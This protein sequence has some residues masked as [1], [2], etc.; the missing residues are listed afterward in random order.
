M[1]DEYIKKLVETRLRSMPPNASFSVGKFG[2]FTRDELI[3][4]VRQGTSVGKATINMEL[5]FLREMPK[6]SK[7][8]R[9]T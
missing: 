6:L 1:V 2:D 9:S 8:S 5:A 4:E 3:E 7:L